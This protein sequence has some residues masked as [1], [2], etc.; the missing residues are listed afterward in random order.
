MTI[1]IYA[2]CLISGPSGFFGGAGGSVS[3]HNLFYSFISFSGPVMHVFTAEVKNSDQ[4][5][6]QMTFLLISNFLF[7]FLLYAMPGFNLLCFII[8]VLN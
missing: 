3:F 2:T 5:L 8:N 7:L 4:K 1:N 6:I